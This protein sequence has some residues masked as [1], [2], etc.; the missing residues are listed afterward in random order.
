MGACANAPI[1]AIDD[2]Y[3]EDLTPEALEK[4]LD[5]LRR[6]EA[7]TPGSARGRQGSMPEGGATTLTDPALYDGSL[8]QP[9]KLP[10]APEPAS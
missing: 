5:A 10:N 7:I 4:L 2:Y 3:Y 6:G 8:A 9:I 1:V